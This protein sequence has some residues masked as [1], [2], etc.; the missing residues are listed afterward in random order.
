M[1]KYLK[2]IKSKIVGFFLSILSPDTQSRRTKCKIVENLKIT[3]GHFVK[4]ELPA[5][6]LPGR[7]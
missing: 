4:G 5:V 3:N 7:V 6:S 1:N 2:A